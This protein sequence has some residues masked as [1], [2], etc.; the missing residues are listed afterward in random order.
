MCSLWVEQ[1]G[2]RSLGECH[3]LTTKLYPYQVEAVE[4][5]LD[6]GQLLVTYEMGLG[7][8]IIAVA[9]AEQLLEDNEIEY[10]VIVCPASLKYQWAQKIAEYTDVDT[11]HIVIRADGERQTITVPTEKYCVVIDGTKDRRKRQYLSL[12]A[13]QPDYVILG[14]ENVVNDWDD[15]RKLH[16]QF[17]VIDEITAIKS[18]GAAR[19]QKI[20]RFTAKLRMGLSGT[21]VE[22]GKPEEAFSIMEWIKDTVLGRPDLFDHTYIVRGKYGGVQRYRNLPLLHQKIA[23]YMSRKTAEDPDVAPYLPEVRESDLM[24]DLDSKTRKVYDR[25]VDDLLL[26]LGNVQSRDSFDVWSYYNGD[27]GY[28]DKTQQGRIMSR[29]QAIDMLLDHPD[30]IV[31]SGQ[32]Y[33]DSWERMKAGE[34]RAS[35]PGSQYCYEI[36]QEG[37]L[38]EITESPK[39]DKVVDSILNVLA[40]NPKNKVIVFSFFRDMVQIL[41]DTL[42]EGAS[43]IYHGGMNSAQKTSA[44][45]KFATDPTCRIFLSTHAGAKGTD[46]FMANYLFNYDLA[47][48][49]GMQDQI[50][51]R[52]RRASSLFEKIAIVNALCRNTTEVRKKAGLAHKR[53]VARAIVD[54][55]GADAKG[56]IEND[57]D[58]LTTFLQDGKSR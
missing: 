34:E 36:W 19:S 56:R 20:K 11:R 42:P 8:T 1:R 32:A 31:L 7:K 50:N 22:N 6:L 16:R 51:G 38:D 44:R 18:F 49:A 3:I 30:L 39:L 4:K 28:D 9:G 14:Y 10:A 25:L 35:W 48:S 5:F 13:A 55:T 52:H 29:I 46:L 17:A 58:S 26:E 47:W 43:V 53:K 40:S 24:V 27:A 33:E 21:P 57:L 54:G 15:V 45:T 41:A 2:R 23:A 12:R 37:L